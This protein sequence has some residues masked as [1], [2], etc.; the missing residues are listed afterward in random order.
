MSLTLGV[1]SA[2]TSV[3]EFLLTAGWIGDWKTRKMNEKG[4]KSS[5]R[6]A[7]VVSKPSLDI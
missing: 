7:Q 4:L 3:P 1:L 2:V 5:N 6:D